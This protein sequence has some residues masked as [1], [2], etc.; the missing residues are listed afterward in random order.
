[1]HSGHL[2]L[3]QRISA[4]PAALG[5]HTHWLVLLVPCRL[6]PALIGS[7]LL[8]PWHSSPATARTMPYKIPAPKAASR[9]RGRGKG[10]PPRP[11]YGRRATPMK[12]AHGVYPICPNDETTVA[13]VEFIHTHGTR[14]LR[15][16]G[17]HRAPL[18]YAS[19]MD[20]ARS[21]VSKIGSAARVFRPDPQSSRQ[22]TAKHYFPDFTIRFPSEHTLTDS[23]GNLEVLPPQDYQGQFHWHDGQGRLTIDACSTATSDGL[24]HPRFFADFAYCNRQLS[25][26]L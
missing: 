11:N 17:G 3:E 25:H 1:M 26:S 19:L 6:G 7:A 2:A 15:E 13:L 22:G 21:H 24:A 20:G 23:T 10:Y 5:F 4:R 16:A 12:S 14:I 8:Q 9:G 18:I